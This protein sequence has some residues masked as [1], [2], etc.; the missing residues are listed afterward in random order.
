M[1]EV[2]RSKF[3]SINEIKA[4]W[5]ILLVATL[6]LLVIVLVPVAIGK[7]PFGSNQEVLNSYIVAKILFGLFFIALMLQ[8]IFFKN[9]R[10]ISLW[11]VVIAIT[12]QI[13]PFTIRLFGF[14][15]QS[16]N[17]AIWIAIYIVLV[18]II[19][20]VVYI[21]LMIMNARMLNADKHYESKKEDL[22]HH[23]AQDMQNSR[24]NYSER[25]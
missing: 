5:P 17:L 23:Y 16:S 19:T 9:A 18:V 1:Q 12:L 22:S 4:K 7:W 6:M 24:D 20:L 2:K 3:V 25:F 14:I 13:T 11:A 10:A 15:K 8:V 21:P